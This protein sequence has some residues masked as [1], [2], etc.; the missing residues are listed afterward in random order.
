MEHGRFQSRRALQARQ[1]SL[2]SWSSIQA[3]GG[4]LVVQ[5]PPQGSSD[6]VICL[7]L[8]L[9]SPALTAAALL[10]PNTLASLCLRNLAR[11]GLPSP[12]PTSPWSLLLPCLHSLVRAASGHT[13]TPLPGTT[14]ARQPGVRYPAPLGPGG[15]GRRER[16]TGPGEGQ[17]QALSHFP[18]PNLNFPTA[19]FLLGPLHSGTLG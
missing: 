18:H 19:Q 7:L 10:P 17:G 12:K 4:S 8:M 6:I 15:Q 11:H 13:P 16:G 3:T 9:F 1:S 14:V 5:G 2:W